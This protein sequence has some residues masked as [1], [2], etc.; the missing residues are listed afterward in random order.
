MKGKKT[1]GRKKGVPNKVTAD[2]RESLK[3]FM[4]LQRP[5]MEKAF[6]RLNPKEKVRAYSRFL[7]FVTPAY[8]S[9]T[10]DLKNMSEDDLE[11]I[12]Q[13]LRRKLAAESE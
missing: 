9:V 4:Q 12:E 10:F 8:S 11:M 2:M 3:L 13:H 7:P 6:K 1:G 5:E